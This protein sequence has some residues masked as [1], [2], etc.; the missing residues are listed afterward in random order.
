MEPWFRNEEQ[1]ALIDY[2]LQGG[3]ITEFKKTEE[4]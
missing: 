1:D 2:M 3:W 4:S